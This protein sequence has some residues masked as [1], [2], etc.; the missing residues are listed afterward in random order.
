VTRRA[1]AQRDGLRLI[2][3]DGYVAFQS[4]TSTER[5]VQR[6]AG[7]TSYLATGGFGSQKQIQVQ[8]Q[9]PDIEELNRLA[10]EVSKHLSEVPGAVDIGL[11]TK[12]KKPELDIAA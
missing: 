3:P 4:P 5:D 11:S 1:H 6:L 9:G 10:A 7:V 8:L 12:G 2:R